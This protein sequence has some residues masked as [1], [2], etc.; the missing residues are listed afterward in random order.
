MVT[1]GEAVASP[2]QDQSDLLELLEVAVPTLGHH[3]PQPTEQVQPAVRIVG[4]PVQQLS[5]E[6]NDTE[7]G[8]PSITASAPQPSALGDVAGGAD[9]AVGD[10]D[11]DTSAS[12]ASPGCARHGA[13]AL[14][15]DRRGAARRSTPTAAA[16]PGGRRGSGK[17]PFATGLVDLVLVVRHQGQAIRVA[18]GVEPGHAA[19]S[20]HPLRHGGDHVIVKWSG[21]PT[22][23][24]E[25][26]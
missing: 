2:V 11:I 19:P 18:H 15:P 13:H 4:R 10:V 25:V 12:I 6:P 23:G 14:T 8:S 24:P 20:P 16:R 22:E 3:A 5:I 17:Q 21:S 9:V 26:A 7:S 1:A